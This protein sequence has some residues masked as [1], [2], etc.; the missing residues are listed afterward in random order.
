MMNKTCFSPKVKELKFFKSKMSIIPNFWN[1]KVKQRNTD[2]VKAKGKIFIWKN[3]T[4]IEKRKEIEQVLTMM[5]P[6]NLKLVKK[7]ISHKYR[8]SI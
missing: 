7:A 5:K 8:M 1:K 2:S 6:E 3:N 4:N